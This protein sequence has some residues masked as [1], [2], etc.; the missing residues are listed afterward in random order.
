MNDSELIESVLRGTIHPDIE[1]I[2]ALNRRQSF[3]A[4]GLIAYPDVERAIMVATFRHAKQKRK[5]SDT[6]YISHLLSVGEL[7]AKYGTNRPH[8][9]AAGILHDIVEDTGY[10]LHALD[11]QF[12]IEVATLVSL[13]TEDMSLK[14]ADNESGTAK[15]TWQQRKDLYIERIRHAKDDAVIICA[16][17]KLHNLET[18]GTDFVLHGPAIWSRFNASPERL[19]W[20]YKSVTEVVSSRIDKEIAVRLS[21]CWDRLQPIFL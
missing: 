7:V 14:D 15:A 16:A 1:F 10:T 18:L 6:P 8:V 19:G 21:K 5:G 11:A 12:G 2:D 20:F 9:W 3:S 13:V 17:D 4:K